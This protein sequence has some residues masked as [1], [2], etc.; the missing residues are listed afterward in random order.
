MAVEFR[1]YDAAKDKKATHTI[2]QECG[3][4]DDEKKHKEAI[5]RFVAASSAWVYTVDDTAEA[6]TITTPGR[7]WHTGTELSLAAVTGVTTSRVA[8]GR[9]AAS[10]TLARSLEES[11]RQGFAVAG[12]GMFEQGFYDR[13][14]FGNGPYELFYRF[15]PAWLKPFAKPAPPQ[16]LGPADWK[17]IHAGRL[18]RLRRHGGVD[19]LPNEVSRC[20]M[21]WVK[22][23]FGLG[24]REDGKLTH[25]FVGRAKGE[26]GPYFIDWL[27]YQNLGQL[28]DL[29][30]IIRGLGAQVRSVQLRE[31]P[32]VQLQALVER[33]FQLQTITRKG[34]HE[35]RLAG[36]AY[37]QLRMLDVERCVAAVCARENVSFTLELYDP[38][39]ERLPE[40]S[41]WKGCGGS[42][43]VELGENSGA[44][45][46]SGKGL[47][48]LRA[49]VNDFTRFWMGSSSAE[50]LEALHSF[51]APPDLIEAL[52]AAVQ[53]PRPYPDWDY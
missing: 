41:Q 4:I 28:R 13:F 50:A 35:S 21:D 52:D 31:I 23:V 24:Y 27:V 33:P 15:D 47:P 48:A 3:W 45:A 2:W 5:D 8:R 12:L 25:F 40:D 42:Y 14:G 36:E 22:N 6:I 1:K 10:G 17:A 11:A 37:W 38:L 9:G 34:P 49:S 18:S 46:G 26:S 53:V 51:E 32:D 29:L 19:L 44:T 30:A 39:A 20:E 7:F 16:R 43:I